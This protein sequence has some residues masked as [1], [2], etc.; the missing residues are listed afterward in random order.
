M[1]RVHNFGDYRREC[2]KDA[3][4]YLRSKPYV[5]REEYI[6]KLE[7]YIRESFDEAVGIAEDDGLDYYATDGF[8]YL[9]SMM[10]PEIP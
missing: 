10:Y 2:I 8:G 5:E 1:A 4:F 9:I 3:E 7:P 6:G